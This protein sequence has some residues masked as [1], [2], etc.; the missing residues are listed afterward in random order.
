[1]SA[2]VSAADV[3]LNFEPRAGIS[4]NCWMLNDEN[5]E[6]SYH[7]SC[8]VVLIVLVIVAVLAVRGASGKRDARIFYKNH[9]SSV[10]QGER[11]L[12]NTVS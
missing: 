4:T 2:E 3:K 12:L 5:Y 9:P 6:S 7:T 10:Y 1:M 11:V 8:G